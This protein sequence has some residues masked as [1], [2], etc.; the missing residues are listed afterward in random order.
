[1]YSFYGG[2]PGNS[3]IIITTYKSID[4]MIQAFQKGNSYTTVHYDEHVL[5]NTE[6]K[7]DPD[8]GKIFR[9]GYDF[10]NSMGGAEYIGTI[11]GPSGNAPMLELSTTAEVKSKMNSENT[12]EEN[13]SGNHRFADARYR[14]GSYNKINNNLVPGK[15]PG[16]ATGTDEDYNDEITWVSYSIR[17]QNNENTTAYIGFTIPYLVVDFSSISVEPYQ[18]GTYTNK[19]GISRVDKG[20][21]PFYEQWEITIPKGVKGN[22]LKNL[23]I[24][25]PTPNNVINGYDWEADHPQT[26]QGGEARD[27]EILVYEEQ[28]YDKHQKGDSKTVYLGDYN[29]IKD[30]ILNDD[31]TFTVSYTH[32]DDYI[33]PK[34]LK[35]I[36][37]VTLDEDG[38]F[39]ITYNHKQDANN[40]STTYTTDLDWIKDISID[41]HGAVT[42][43]HTDDI[44]QQGPIIKWCNGVNLDEDGTLT[45]N[46]NTEEPGELQEKIQW[47]KDVELTDEG[48]LKVTYNTLEE[49]QQN[50]EKIFSNKIKWIEDMS[51]DN[52]TGDLTVIYNTIDEQ[53]E[54][55]YPNNRE[56]T[57]FSNALKSISSIRRGYDEY[58]SEGHKGRL[59]INYTDNDTDSFYFDS[60]SDIYMDQSTGEITAQWNENENETSSLGSLTFIKDLFID[61]SGVLLIKYSNLSGGITV[62][63]DPGWFSLGK[64]A[65][66]GNNCDMVVSRLVRGKHFI[67]PNDNKTYLQFYLENIGLV[68]LTDSVQ[69]NSGTLV[70]YYNGSQVGNNEISLTNVSIIEEASNDIGENTLNTLNFKIEL[71]D[72]EFPV[73]PTSSSPHIV[74]IELKNLKIHVGRK[75]TADRIADL[76]SQQ[77]QQKINDNTEN[78]LHLTETVNQMNLNLQSA[79]NRITNSI[80]NNQLYSFEINNNTA[81]QIFNKTDFYITNPIKVVYNQ[82]FA[83]IKGK[84]TVKRHLKNGKYVGFQG[85]NAE[86]GSQAYHMLINLS[87]RIPH[88]FAI[89]GTQDTVQFIADTEGHSGRSFYIR[90]G[91]K[92]YFK[93]SYFGWGYGYY[94]QNNQHHIT[95]EEVAEI[96]AIIPFDIDSSQP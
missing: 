74:D 61:T 28:N 33:L 30:V 56:T 15:I 22:S 34:R 35:W 66:Y 82:Y 87:G 73:T 86:T 18:G 6:N 9:R 19:N 90:D 20:E 78:I 91:C 88:K 96:D 10:S 92:I 3:F 89:N 16:K 80:N 2:R 36:D 50:K 67:D 39:T 55:I 62:D 42:F 27:R 60:L 65:P 32:E 59:Y 54:E 11:V 7:N 51:I 24:A 4:K 52:N 77:V 94:Y 13:N 25:T 45:F 44:T 8:N 17:D 68:R 21:H 81:N 85:N 70:F 84:V 63:G 58:S 23:R 93:D 5:I 26:T 72:S 43:I 83:I 14:E 1:M 69:I 31:G 46:W 76:Q 41:S 53:S 49:N 37:Q 95:W 40:N 29:I 57:I 71:D 79:T 64:I 12:F 47:I 75:N 38:H 48:T